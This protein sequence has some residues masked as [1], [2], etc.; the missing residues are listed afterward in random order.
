MMNPMA[1][2]MGGMGGGAGPAVS[3]P[4]LVLQAAKELSPEVAADPRGFMLRCALPGHM[5]GA[6]IGQ[7]GAGTKEVQEFTGTKISI[8]GSADEKTRIMSI[9]GPLLNVCAA[10]M[11]MM[12][13]YIN[14]EQESQAASGGAQVTFPF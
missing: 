5:V 2:M 12:V 6:L 13:R 4:Q 7:G 8:P 9:E 10:Y 14:S 11:L 3:G 1:A